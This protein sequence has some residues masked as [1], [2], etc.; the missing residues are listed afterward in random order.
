MRMS[1]TYKKHI[2][3]LEGNWTDDLAI[4]QSMVK[5]LEFLEVVS[6]IKHIHKHCATKEQLKLYLEKYKQKRYQKYSICYL[7]FHGDPELIYLTKKETVHLDEI[8]EMIGDSM[9]N[10]IIHFG[11]CSTL[12]IHKKKILSFLKKTNALAVSGYTSDVD[13]LPS[14]MFDMLFF[15]MCQQ[16]RNITC[17]DRDM[18]LYYGKLIK[19]LGFRLYYL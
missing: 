8:A 17:I 1:S 13:F 16:Y 10:K 12:S 4:K 9:K 14:S 3:C 15:E 2:Y 19:Q 5:A 7:A 18:K 6:E 11:S